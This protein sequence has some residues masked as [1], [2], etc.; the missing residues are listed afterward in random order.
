MSS[1]CVGLV[2]RRATGGLCG[3]TFRA[4]CCPVSD[5]VDVWYRRL[6][7]YHL[8]LVDCRI[9]SDVKEHIDKPCPVHGHANASCP[10]VE[11]NAKHCVNSQ[12]GCRLV[13][14]GVAVLTAAGNNDNDSCATTPAGSP[15]TITVGAVDGKGNRLRSLDSQGSNY[16]SCVDLYAPGH[17]VPGASAEGDHQGTVRSGTSQ[18]VALAT[19][20]AAMLLH[21]NPHLSPSELRQALVASGAAGV[22]DEGQPDRANGYTAPLLQVAELGSP[23]HAQLTPSV[24]R[25]QVGRG[26]LNLVYR[27]KLAFAEPASADV[28][29]LL[30]ERSGLRFNTPAWSMMPAGSVSGTFDL[31]INETIALSTSDVKS[32]FID[33]TLSSGDR[34]LDGRQLPVQVQPAPTALPLYSLYCS[35]C[36]ELAHL[37][38]SDL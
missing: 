1:A 5:C 37:D 35:P 8:A 32:F 17:R 38:L 3:S 31:V 28:K 18:A 29:V 16:G 2:T 26:G 36:N 20:A 11:P 15:F 21:A 12:C 27:M 6:H 23:P 33:V 7:A 30:S 22:V 10:Y 25:T 19:G 34:K 4:M 24:L 14:K 13:S 9:E